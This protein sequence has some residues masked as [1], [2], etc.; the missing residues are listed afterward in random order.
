[1][2]VNKLKLIHRN[3]NGLYILP[4]AVIVLYKDAYI[5]SLIHIESRPGELWVNIANRGTLRLMRR[6]PWI[7]YESIVSAETEEV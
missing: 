3:D 4:I 7:F 5:Q 1:M 6:K 2:V